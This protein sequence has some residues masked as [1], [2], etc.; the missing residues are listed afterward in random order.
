[1]KSLLIAALLVGSV[2][3]D[4]TVNDM[5]DNDTGQRTVEALTLHI[6]RADY[7]TIWMRCVGRQPL[8]FVEWDKLPTSKF[9]VWEVSMGA[10]RPRK[11]RFTMERSD[12][13]VNRGMMF[14]EP[15]KF[16]SF[17]GDGTPVTFTAFTPSGS[18]K[19]TL[20][21]YGTATAW[22]RVDDNCESDV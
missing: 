11:A 21:V 3:D 13:A 10:D 2:G 16:V 20:Q 12:D 7:V 22:K 19:V 6:D 15:A 4:W 14:V 5:T 1:M 17:V 18:E 9:M 8:I